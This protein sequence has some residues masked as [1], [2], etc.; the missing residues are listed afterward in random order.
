M[1]RQIIS[2]AFVLSLIACGGKQ[3][4][5]PA[6]PTAAE[7]APGAERKT[8]AQAECESAGGTVV[9]D[10]G[11]GATHRPD[12]VCPSGKAPLGNVAASGGGIAIEGQV[13]CP[14]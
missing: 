12:Y 11:D 8:L 5:Q 10:I 7:P 3:A 4:A 2:A 6:P 1:K 13:C 14:R 9:G